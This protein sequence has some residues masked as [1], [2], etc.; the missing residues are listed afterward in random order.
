MVG[1]DIIMKKWETVKEYKG[2]YR[3]RGGRDGRFI[4]PSHLAADS[5]LTVVPNKRRFLGWR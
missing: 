3:K 4:S 1:L 5:P 2:A